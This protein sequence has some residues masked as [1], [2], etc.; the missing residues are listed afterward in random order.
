M[1][2]KR[3]AERLSSLRNQKGISAREMSLAIG[4]NSS[5][6]NHIENS[7]IMPSMLAF[8]N[9]CEYLNITPQDFFDFDNRFPSV[10]NEL[11]YNLH[12]LNEEEITSINTIIKSMV[13]Q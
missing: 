13:R 1:Y 4:Q 3:F 7:Q 5:Y 12:K 2:E 6:I 9:I 8:F 11:L 10:N